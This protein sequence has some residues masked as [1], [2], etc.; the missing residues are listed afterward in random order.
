[1]PVIPALEKLR[2]KDQESEISLNYIVNSKPA[3]AGPKRPASAPRRVQQR[4][5]D[6]RDSLPL[7]NSGTFSALFVFCTS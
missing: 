3:C 7:L 2:Q 1:M 5:R 6:F 4:L